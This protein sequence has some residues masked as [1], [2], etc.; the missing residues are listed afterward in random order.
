MRTPEKLCLK[1]TAS[2]TLIAAHPIDIVW[3]LGEDTIDG[4][5]T[6]CMGDK[7][8]LNVVVPACGVDQDIAVGSGS[9]PNPFY[10]I[11]PHCQ[12][13]YKVLYLPLYGREFCCKK[14]WDIGTDEPPIEPGEG[15]L[16]KLLKMLMKVMK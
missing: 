1:L 3:S 14:C 12:T 15:Q 7:P 8:V 4:L 6:W 11:C 5:L 9:L 16:A 2:S 10:F 13:S